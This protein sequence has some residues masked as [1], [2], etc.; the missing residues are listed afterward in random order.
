MFRILII[1]TVAALVLPAVAT[2]DNITGSAC[3]RFSDQE[4]ISAAREIALSMA[5]RDALEGYSV[6]VGS[7]SV[8]QNTTLK[9]DLITSITGGLL[10]NVRITSQS[11]DFQKREICRTI[12]ADVEPIELKQQVA[13]Q[14]RAY[15]R[16][17]NPVDTG[18]PEN[19][20]LRILQIRKFVSNNKY[21][22]YQYQGNTFDCRDG[23][24]AVSAQCKIKTVNYSSYTTP[25]VR[26]TWI[27]NDGIPE[28]SFK[29][30]EHC[31]NAGDTKQY[32]VPA[33]PG[34]GYTFSVEVIAWYKYL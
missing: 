14:L 24:I 6:F 30:L 23:C 10:K 15:Q 7:S 17:T 11:E 13:A 4:S 2:A 31:E 32:I 29:D 34:S 20:T 5:K 19:E 1:S 25:G 22:A 27:N 21:G 16:R 12:N 33:P 8:V 28:V 26:I 18:L 3:Y 9:N